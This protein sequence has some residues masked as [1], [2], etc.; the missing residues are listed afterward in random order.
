MFECCYFAR[1]C[2]QREFD[3]TSEVRHYISPS[4]GDIYWS[5]SNIRRES[6]I[7]C[8]I[9]YLKNY[10]DVQH[11]N[12]PFICPNVT[13]DNPVYITNWDVEIFCN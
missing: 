9:V 8:Q 4:E 11:C 10:K 3:K 1:N 6:S 7:Q 13:L 12:I 5:V 2:I